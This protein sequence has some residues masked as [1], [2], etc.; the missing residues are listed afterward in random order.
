MNT[1]ENSNLWTGCE[2]L[3]ESGI[4]L[5]WVRKTLLNSEN[6]NPTTLIIT[7]LPTLWFPQR[8]LGNYEL[9][10][11]EVVSFQ[12]NRLFV[13]EGAEEKLNQINIGL[14]E[15]L[16]LGRHPWEMEG[17]GYIFPTSSS[18]GNND[19][20]TDLSPVPAPR[21]PGPSPIS[22]EMEPPLD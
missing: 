9:L 8:I 21:W 6:H 13:F 20:G 2:V 14:L 19:N 16:G 5:G 17:D 22:Y 10:V 1:L 15:C 3:T 12:S 11:S 7:T 4:P 18:D